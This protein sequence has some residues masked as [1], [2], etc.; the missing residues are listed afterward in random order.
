LFLRGGREY[1]GLIRERDGS[2]SAENA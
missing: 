2:D 1:M